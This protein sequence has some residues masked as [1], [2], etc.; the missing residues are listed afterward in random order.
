MRILVTGGAGYVAT[1]TL[2]ELL[3]GSSVPLIIDNFVNSSPI[4]LA[5]VETLTGKKLTHFHVSLTDHIKLNKI[6]E[7]FKPDAVMHFAGLK[8]VGESNQ[9][10]V[11]Y[12]EQN[13]SGTLK[14]LNAMDNVGCKKIIFS[15][16]ATVY[17][18]PNYLPIDE[19]H[20]LKP[21]SVYGRSKLF[22]EKILRDWANTDE[23]KSAVLLRYFNPVGAH[24]SGEIGEDPKGIPNNLF[25]LMAEAALGKIEK[26]QIFG[27]DYNTIDG[28]GVRDYIHVSDVARGHIAALDHVMSKNGVQAVN[29]GV[30]KGYSVFEVLDAFMAVSGKSI[31]YSIASRRVGDVSTSVASVEKASQ[32]WN[33]N[34]I[35]DLEEVC[36]SV[37]KWYSKNPNGYQM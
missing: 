27:D 15:S 9:Y 34:A 25:P 3:H 13:I 30:G 37:W 8:S 28:T 22:V 18:S 6:L 7:N 20:P 33:W 2:I 31:R 29:L 1:H 12:Y 32:L 4:A 19:N 14:L 10:P 24:K 16:S 23:K 21:T 36:K 11:Q 26:L 35:F 17:G 5:R